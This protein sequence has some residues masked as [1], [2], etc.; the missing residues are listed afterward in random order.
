MASWRDIL[1]ELQNQLESLERDLLLRDKELSFLREIDSVLTQA[2]FDL[3]LVFEKIMK[4]ALDFTQGASGQL[5]IP[6]GSKLK[7]VW[8]SGKPAE[9]GATVDITDSVTGRAYLKKR[10]HNVPNVRK[11]KK[12]QKYLENMRSELA[13]PLM[14]GNIPI[15]IINLESPNLRAFK[16]HHIEMIN[17]LAGQASLAIKIANLLEQLSFLLNTIGSG[18]AGDQPITGALKAVTD[19]AKELT[20]ADG[21]QILLVKGNEL[22]IRFSTDGADEGGRV[23]IFDSVSGRAVQKRHAIIRHDVSKDRRYQGILKDMHSELAVPVIV[24][25]QVVGVLNVESKE[26]AAFYPHDALM[27]QKF[28]NQAGVLLTALSNSEQLAEA[29]HVIGSM[30]AMAAV[31][32]RAGNLLHRFKNPISA[33]SSIVGEIKEK[34]PMELENPFL[35]QRLDEIYDASVSAIKNVEEFSRDIA[36]RPPEE[37]EIIEIEPVKHVVGVLESLRKPSNV[38]MHKLFR[39]NVPKIKTLPGFDDIVYNLVRN[40]LDALKAGGDLTIRVE[41]FYN[42]LAN[43]LDG[44]TIAVEDTGEGIPSERLREIFDFRTTKGLGKGTGFG[45]WWTKRFLDRVG[46][47]IYPEYERSKGSKF[48]VFHPLYPKF[49]NGW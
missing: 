46:G 9:V 28:A 35:K 41:P 17:T 13:V 42:K 45:L 12:Y 6:N 21:C 20:G 15:G 32:D 47:E 37:D 44:I 24:S 3:Q 27:L 19:R 5:L 11:D 48:T 2:P 25:D 14:E 31:G 49:R 29:Q 43:R 34:C 23:S 18:S 36:G 7:I 16:S 38:Q 26:L 1:T 39:S 33:I 22:L 30:W 40:A 8:T 4:G 10:W